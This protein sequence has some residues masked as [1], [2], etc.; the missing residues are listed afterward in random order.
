[1]SSSSGAF[2]QGGQTHLHKLRMLQQVVGATFKV[3]LWIAFAV[4][5]GLVYYYHSWQ[6]FWLIGVYAKAWFMTNCPATISSLSPSSLIH[7]ADGSSQSFSDS[8]IMNSA[9][10]H[11]QMEYFMWTGIKK[12]IQSLSVGMVGSG[13]ISWFWTRKGSKGQEKEIISGLELVTPK[14]LT[15]SVK[16]FGASHYSIANIPTPKDSEFY[17]TMVSGTTGAGKSN[18]L[19]HLLNQI[20]ANGDQAIVVDTTGTFVSGFFD[21]DKDILLNPFDTRS[22]PWNMWREMANSALVKEVCAALIPPVP[23][24]DPFWADTASTVLGECMLHL[25]DNNEMTYKNLVE[26]ILMMPLET[27]QDRLKDTPANILVEKSVEKTANNIRMTLVKSIEGFTALEESFGGTSLL[28]RMVSDDK[29][30][31]FLACVPDQRKIL[32]SIFSAQ[33]SLIISGI[34]RRPVVAEEDRQRIWIIIDELASLNEIPDLRSALDEVRKFG[35]CM[36]LGFQDFGQLEAI[37]GQETVSSFSNLTGTKILLRC[38]DPKIAARNANYFGEQEIKETTESI[39]FGAHQMR[40][41][42]SL[43]E[44]TYTKPLVTGTDI[45]RLRDLEA[46]LK[47]SQ[48]LPVAKVKFEYRHKTQDIPACMPKPV[49]TRFAKHKVFLDEAEKKQLINTNTNTKAVSSN[50]ALPLIGM[51]GKNMH[52]EKNDGLATEFMAEFAREEKKIHN[53]Q[54]SA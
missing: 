25:M 47:F 9:N 28:N 33:L 26:M 8:M 53:H 35:G 10:M 27:L 37:Y 38:E 16:E 7:M 42:V 4:F 51:P 52:V 50:N 32:R 22:T 11:Y 3:G 54:V 21:S 36:V 30:W 19:N 45:L 43:S 41:G 13:L 31:I 39:S 17:H 23:K 1:M 18:M 34:K 49:S 24:R 5:I 6:E 15:K 44:R 40:D 12:L 2:T 29:G 20:R 46:Y 48:G 14:K